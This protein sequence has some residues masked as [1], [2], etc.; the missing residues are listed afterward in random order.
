MKVMVRLAILVAALLLVNNLA[1]AAPCDQEFCYDVA[2]TDQN[3][4][5]LAGTWRVCLYDDGRGFLKDSGSQYILRL[6]GGG[7]GWF[8][9]NGSPGF[10]N[11]DPKF[12]EWVLHSSAISYYIHPLEG[13]ALLSAIG[14]GGNGSVWFS[15]TAVQVPLA[16]CSVSGFD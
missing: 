1:F 12:T 8:N 9:T 14:I 11:G 3:G 10:T 13:G 5:P 7:P 15:T 2:S 4:I 16:S 6:F